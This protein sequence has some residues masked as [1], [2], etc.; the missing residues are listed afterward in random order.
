MGS[1]IVALRIDRRP[2]EAYNQPWRLESAR[3]HVNENNTAM[4]N[5]PCCICGG[6]RETI[7][8]AKRGLNV[9]RCNNCGLVF[10][11]PRLSHEDIIRLYDESYFKG[12]GFDGNVRYEMDRKIVVKG[13]PAALKPEKETIL[14]LVEKFI[15]KGN[16]LDMGCGFGAMLKIAGTRGWKGYGIEVSDYAAEVAISGGLDVKRKDLEKGDFPDDYFSAVLMCDVIEH[17]ENPV[18]TLK[19]IHNMMRE[20]SILFIS[21][22]DISSIN[23]RFHGKNWKYIMPEGHLYYFSGKTMFKALE[24]A[25]FRVKATFPPANDF[26]FY[27]SPRFLK[28]GSTVRTLSG[29]NLSE[30]S[31]PPKTFAEKLALGMIKNAHAAYD[32]LFAGSMNVYAEKLNIRS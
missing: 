15:P 7:L 11:N 27:K 23:A 17:L 13:E 8:F 22:G 12:A 28:L 20:E 30:K 2:H 5:V 24:A 32:S 9:V 29:F 6:M 16:M 4:K 21:T 14:D 31:G 1:N 18:R 26:D 10:V 25:G 19:I 3:M